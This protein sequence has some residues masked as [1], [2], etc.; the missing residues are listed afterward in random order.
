[1]ALPVIERRT[2]DRAAL[3][4]ISDG[5]DTASNASLR[6]LKSALLRSD[7]F[8]YAI[9]ID[10]SATQAINSRVNVDTLRDITAETGGR[11]EVV[12]TSDDLVDATAR[13]ADELNSQ[14]LLGYTSPKAA[15]GTFHSIR[16]RVSGADYRVRARN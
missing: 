16:V 5:A 13:I 10:S 6:D 2:R 1:E 4:I 11:T 15:D 8:V 12:K 9:A 3:V 7:V 14:Y